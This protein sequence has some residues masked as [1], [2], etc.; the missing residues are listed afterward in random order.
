MSFNHNHVTLVGRLT[1]DPKIKETSKSSKATFHLAVNRNYISEDGVAETDFIPIVLWGKLAG[2]SEKYLK[3]G[4]AVLVEGRIQVRS[5][6]KEGDMHWITE[7]IA[8][9]FQILDSKS[10][11]STSK[12][13]MEKVAR[14]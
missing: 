14:K 8:N 5:Y 9:N 4:S 1:K 13:K 12:V 11:K 10:L 2:L 7:V 3:K 6:E